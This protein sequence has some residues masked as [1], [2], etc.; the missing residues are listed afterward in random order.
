[1]AVR[2]LPEEAC[3]AGC[4]WKDGLRADLR[5]FIVRSWDVNLSSAGETQRGILSM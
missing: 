1:M 5:R 2:R 3:V 4:A